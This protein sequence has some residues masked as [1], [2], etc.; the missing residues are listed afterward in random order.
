MFKR[1]ELKLTPGRLAAALAA[2][3]VIAAAPAFAQQAPKAD[4]PSGQP[5]GTATTGAGQLPT[6]Q[7]QSS[8]ARAPDIT[9]G[10]TGAQS[11]SQ[12]SGDRKE[13]QAAGAATTRAGQL[14][15][16]QRQAGPGGKDIAGERPAGQAGVASDS[17]VG[18]SPATGTQPA[19]G[20]GRGNQAAGEA[21][22]RAGQLPT[23]QRLP[24]AGSGPDISTKPAQ[25]GTTR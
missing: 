24:K 25:P 1:S 17:A 23:D 6:D 10:Q 11:G 2:A 7:R 12:M 21:T 3:G 22:T 8:G 4:Q 9:G 16:D 19:A 20:T 13:G 18:S 15:T 14:P 5:S